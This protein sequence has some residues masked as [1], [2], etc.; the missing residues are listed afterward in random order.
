MPIVEISK[1]PVDFL[2]AAVEVVSYPIRDP[3]Q[4]RLDKS[5]IVRL[6]LA[7][8]DDLKGHIDSAPQFRKRLLEV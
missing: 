8:C 6:P 5:V 4:H 2:R 1:R 7:A 3:R